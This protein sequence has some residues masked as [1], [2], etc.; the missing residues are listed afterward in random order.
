MRQRLCEASFLSLGGTVAGWIFAG[1]FMGVL[2]LFN[3]GTDTVLSLFLKKGH[4][5]FQLQ[6]A[7]MAGHYILVM[8][9]TILAAIF[10]ARN[11]AKL[12]P[13][14]ALRTAK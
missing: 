1:I 12:S 6:P 14:A 3:F 5:S 9:L 10:P 7:S 11:A 4:F 2:S 8:I 13:A